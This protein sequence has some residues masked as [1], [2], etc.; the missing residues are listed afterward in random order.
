MPI[1]VPGNP[2]HK[3]ISNPLSALSFRSYI[4]IVIQPIL[5]PPEEASRGGK[6]GIIQVNFPTENRFKEKMLSI[7][8]LKNKRVGTQ[9]CQPVHVLSGPHRKQKHQK[10]GK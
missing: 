9:V 7:V 3:N 4:K 5:I 8:L 2:C 1:E 6:V 10:L